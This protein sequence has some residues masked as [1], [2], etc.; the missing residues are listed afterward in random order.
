MTS[1]V[2]ELDYPVQREQPLHPPCQYA[3]LRE[4]QPVC[5]VKLVTGHTAY[6]VTRYEDVRRVLSDARFSREA[7]FQDGAPR[8]QLI[9]PDSDSLIS[10]DAPRHTLLRQLINREFTPRRVELLRP[11]I[12]ALVDA[13]LDRM[14]ERGPVVD[15]NAAFS[16][17]LAMGIICELLGIPAEDQEKFVSWADH[18]TSLRKYTGAE[19][20]R[21][22]EEMRAYF[23]RLI[24]EKRRHPGED[25]LS[26]L[27]AA[28]D[29]GNRLT[30]RELVSLGVILVLAGHDT[31]VTAMNGGT[32]LLL[33]HPD[34][35]EAFR[36]G[37]E[38]VRSA[39]EE[40]VRMAT[41]GDGIFMRVTLEDVEL[42]GTVVPA[43]S[44]VIAPISAANRD[45]SVFEDPDSFDI[46]RVANP[47]IGFAV[48]THFCAGSALARAELEIGLE[49]LFRRF[50]SLRLAVDA[51]EL[52]W[53][54]YS[55]LGGFEELPVTW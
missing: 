26:A 2:P 15:L 32:V 4:E 18:F 54:H 27:V 22:N 3:R 21:S 48:G 50:P 23:L 47:H 30:L 49:A 42:S 24:E 40:I 17:P 8:A 34:Q 29:E 25:L 46:G 38:A 55:H 9:E 14:G 41:P 16:R 51:K 33:E 6:L 5:P 19:M 43:G 10:M 12:A 44:G 37:P 13:L 7:L 39:V 28:M 11:R 20:A 1:A 31:T 45:P 52:S 53:R 36:S 35:L